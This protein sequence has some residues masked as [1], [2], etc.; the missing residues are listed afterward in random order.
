MY[1]CMYVCMYACMYVCMYVCMC[2][3]VRADDGCERLIVGNILSGQPPSG[4]S[5][6]DV[7]TKRQSQKCP[8]NRYEF[9]L[10]M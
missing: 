6:P 4:C 5:R 7:M 1:V 9:G 2:V 8:N 10:P 3:R